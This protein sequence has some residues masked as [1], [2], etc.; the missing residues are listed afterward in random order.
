[1]TGFFLMFA[2]AGAAFSVDR[3]IRIR[4]GAEGHEIRPRAPWAQ[5]MIQF[6]LSLMY[7]TSFW[8]KMKGHTS[9]DG[10]AHLLRASSAL[11]PA[12]SPAAVDTIDR[13]VKSG[14]LVHLALEFLLGS[15]SGSGGFV[16]LCCCSACCS[17]YASNTRSIFQCS[18]GTC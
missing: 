15:S 14:Q 6:E 17:I 5:R 7:L 11:D 9:L 18:P 4:R 13:D 1:M 8:W 16:I 12:V 2:P 10:T 3:L